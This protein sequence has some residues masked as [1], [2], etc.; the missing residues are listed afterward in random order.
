MRDRLFEQL[1]LSRETVLFCEEREQSLSAYFRTI[2]QT[3]D[4][5]QWKVIE[6][7]QAF[8]VSERHLHGTTGYGHQDDGRDTLEKVY[9]RIF[10]GEDALVRPQI[11]S[12]TNALYL[13]LSACLRPGDEAVF[14]VGMPYDTLQGVMGLRPEIGS[15]KEYGVESRIAE[16]TPEGKPDPAAIRAAITEKTRLVE[17]QRSRGYASRDSLSPEEIGE[18]IRL[19]KG[20]REDIIVMVDNC[21]GEFVRTIEPG[22]VGADLT[23]GSLIKNPGGGLAPIGGYIVGRADLIERC[24]ARL[25]APGIGKDGGATLTAN[26]S[27]YQGL[28]RAPSVTASALKTA[29]FAAKVFEDLGYAVSPSSAAPRQDIVQAVECQTPEG[30]LAFCRGIQKAAPVDSYVVPEGSDMPGY[31]TPVVMAAGGFVSGASIEL[32]ADGPMRPPYTAYFQGGLTWSHG[33]L[34]I[35]HAVE[36]M[37]RAGQVTLSK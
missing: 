17:I 22:D 14:A 18:I 8:R 1:A 29:I 21:Y 34:G 10:H 33:K 35:M 32:S 4:Y 26:R 15:L 12:G 13:T 36:A 7:M 31:D 27:F 16:L 6:A 11:I 23:V 19:V 24:A 28:F 9:A 2:D 3:A 37:Y 20:I 30:L 25:T 5:N